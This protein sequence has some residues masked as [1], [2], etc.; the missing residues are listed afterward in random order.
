[1]KKKTPGTVLKMLL[2]SQ[3]ASKSSAAAECLLSSPLLSDQESKSKS[4]HTT[5]ALAE[6]PLV[7]IELLEAIRISREGKSMAGSRKIFRL[8]V[9]V[10]VLEGKR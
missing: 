4:S 8:H 10:F 3:L 9:W 2:P 5:H 1:M 7:Y 6:P